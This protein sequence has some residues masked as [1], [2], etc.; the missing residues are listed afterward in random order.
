MSIAMLRGTPRNVYLTSKPL[1]AADISCNLK[2]TT[3]KS[4]FEQ[5]ILSSSGRDNPQKPLGE[6]IFIQ[7]KAILLQIVGNT[8]FRQ[9]CYKRIRRCGE[10]VPHLYI[11]R[12]RVNSTIEA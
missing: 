10:G 3:Y 4:S 1:T 5:T 7:T 11:A 2:M 6:P 9:T 12:E 8:L